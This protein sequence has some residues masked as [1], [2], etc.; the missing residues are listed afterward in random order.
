MIPEVDD[1]GWQDFATKVI[2]EK[3]AYQNHQLQGELN[4]SRLFQSTSLSKIERIVNIRPEK[5]EGE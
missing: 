5:L 2:D 3:K 1:R 4:R